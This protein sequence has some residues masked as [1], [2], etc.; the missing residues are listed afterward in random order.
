MLHNFIKSYKDRPSQAN[1]PF[2]SQSSK[3]TIVSNFA[4]V[5]SD[6]FLGL[7]SQTH[8]HAHRFGVMLYLL[9]CN[10]FWFLFSVIYPMTFHLACPVFPGQYS[11]LPYYYYYF[12]F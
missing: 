1:L 11:D 2:L 5:V 7:D 3:V 12:A 10:R 6:I 8:T 9:V 4:Y